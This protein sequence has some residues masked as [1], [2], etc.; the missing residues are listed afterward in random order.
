MNIISKTPKVELLLQSH[1]LLQLNNKEQAIAI[2]C[3]N[4]TVWLT[5]EGEFRDQILYSG[6]SYTPKMKGR[7]VIEALR[8]SCID[9]EVNL[10]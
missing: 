8:A 7:I 10:N 4:G 3:K 1:D 6:R 5:C 9:I 2:S